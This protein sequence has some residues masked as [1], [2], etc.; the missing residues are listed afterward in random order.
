MGRR[1]KRGTIRKIK[2]GKWTKC[3]GYTK[4][5]MDRLLYVARE[6]DRNV[7]LDPT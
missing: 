3:H 7:Q 2:T 1:T 6:L 4:R 5:D